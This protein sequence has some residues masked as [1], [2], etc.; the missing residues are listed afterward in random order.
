MEE[1]ILT[2]IKS[3]FPFQ[4]QHIDIGFNYLGYYL[5]PNNYKKEDWWWFQRKV[6]KRTS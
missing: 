6:E 3:F 5:K 2:R 4:V 1:D